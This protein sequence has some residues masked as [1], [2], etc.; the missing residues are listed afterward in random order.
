VNEP[1]RTGSGTNGASGNWSSDAHDI[2]SSGSVGT[3]SVQAWS[4]SAARSKGKNITPGVQR[5]DGIDG[6][7]DRRDHAEVAVAAAQRPEQVRLVLR[8]DT[9]RAS[10]GRGRARSR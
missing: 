5:L 7:L 9:G 8:V 4:T 1:P 10:V 6:E 2:I 3:S